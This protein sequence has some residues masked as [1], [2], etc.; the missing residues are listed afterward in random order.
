[1]QNGAKYLSV[2][3][4]IK[5]QYLEY[6]QLLQFN[7]KKTNNPITNWTGVPAMAQWI[8]NPTAVARVSAMA[9]TQF[10]A[11]EFPYAISTAIEKKTG[12]RIWIDISPKMK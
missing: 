9:Q 3:Y 8:K 7:N 6:I 12:H 2:I 4:L 1:M 10:L 11:W 5:T